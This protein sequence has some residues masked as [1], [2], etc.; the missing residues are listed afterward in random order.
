M[1]SMKDLEHCIKDY[2][3]TENAIAELQSINHNQTSPK[4]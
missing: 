4:K 1:Q 2:E 3:R